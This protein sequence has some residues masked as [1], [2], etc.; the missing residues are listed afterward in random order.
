M[1]PPRPRRRGPGGVRRKS[2]GSRLRGSDGAIVVHLSSAQLAARLRMAH[3]A[4]SILLSVL[5]ILVSGVLGGLAGWAVIALLGLTGLGGALLAA[6]VGMVVATGVW[7]GLTVLGRV[8]G[9]VQ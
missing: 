2:P 8:L 7:I 6:L 4:R 9:F 1:L 3:S 5:G